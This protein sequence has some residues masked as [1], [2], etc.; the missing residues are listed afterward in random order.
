VRELSGRLACSVGETWRDLVNDPVVRDLRVVIDSGLFGFSADELHAIPKLFGS[1]DTAT[2]RGRLMSFLMADDPD[3]P[4]SSKELGQSTR[5]NL[6]LFGATAETKLLTATGRRI[7]AGKIYRPSNPVSADGI[8]KHPSA[9]Q[10]KGGPEW[11]LLALL[12]EQMPASSVWAA[13][14]PRPAK[15]QTATLP[16]TVT[17]ALGRSWRHLNHLVN[18]RPEGAAV[19]P[20][21]I[22]DAI[23]ALSP[24]IDYILHTS[25]PSTR[26]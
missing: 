1:S 8:R 26:R 19:I 22:R 7:E 24:S 21:D 9:K 4:P 3:Q 2:I 18:S 11:W 6:A 12:R 13:S 10:P 20:D 14:G 15:Q 17:N 25:M 16:L 5:F 23:F